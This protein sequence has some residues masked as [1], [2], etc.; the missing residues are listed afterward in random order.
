M[1]RVL[2]V[3]HDQ[4]MGDQ[5][6]DSLRGAGYEVEQ[7]AGPTFGPCPILHG[8]P[9]FAVEQADVLVYDV[10]A[11][12]DTNT[13]RDLIEL[14][15]EQHPRIPIVLTAPGMEFDWVETSGLHGVTPL[16][17]PASGERLGQAIGEALTSVA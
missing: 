12:G 10:W 2:V 9:C 4:D 17:G 5:E 13:E 15:R 7:C 16:V 3:H 6:A 1:T 11:S 8:R 14:L